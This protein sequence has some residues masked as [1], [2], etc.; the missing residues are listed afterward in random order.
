M[1]NTKN[2][3]R[4]MTRTAAFIAMLVVLQMVTAPLGN[5]F[6]TGAIVNMLL[7]IAVM[8]GGLACGLSVAVISP[9]LAKLVGI[10][11]LWVLI[12][13]IVIGN[14]ALVSLWFWIGNREM[15]HRNMALILALL[16]AAVLKFL[17]LFTGIVL[18]LVPVFLNL[19]E[20]QTAVVTS[21]FSI[22]QLINALSGGTLAMLLLPLL[23][24]AEK[25]E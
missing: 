17:I 1:V 7:I 14:A 8:T 3:I 4:W 19:N 6:V 2:R 13:V 20:Q 21:M 25:Q 12:P 9:V 5:T 11:P 15:K 18:I 16:S 22:P 10:G 24:K 23:K